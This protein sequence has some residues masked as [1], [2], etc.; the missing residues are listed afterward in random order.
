MV[1][2]RFEKRVAERLPV[3][4][5]HAREK[6]PKSLREKDWEHHGRRSLD[7]HTSRAL[8]IATSLLR[9]R[10]D[11][12]DVVQETLVELWQRSPH[13]DPGRGSAAA[14]V[15]TIA[16][17]RA[18]D[19]LRAI[20]SARRALEAASLDLQPAPAPTLDEMEDLRRDYLRIY[21]A[22]AALSPKQH[23]V[24]H[25]AYFEGL[26]QA[27]IAHR[28]HIPLGTVKLRLRTATAKVGRLLR[29]FRSARSAP[30]PS[31]EAALTSRRTVETGTFRGGA[32]EG[33]GARGPNPTR[34]RPRS[35]GRSPTQERHRLASRR[36]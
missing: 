18:I 34:K 3:G 10:R 36:R 11:A 12:E 32:S 16:R 35:R 33:A 22:L 24:I 30:R 23:A 17:S 13:F 15:V 14:W 6:G 7:E 1:I 29:R 8:S 4:P 31:T 19:R 20:A 27:E 26:S 5:T 2:R 25:L 21:A 9:D 28:T